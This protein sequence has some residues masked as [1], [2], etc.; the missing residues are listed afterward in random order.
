MSN[1]QQVPTLNANNLSAPLIC[2]SS[3]AKFNPIDPE[4]LFLLS[5]TLSSHLTRL[6]T[7]YKNLLFFKTIVFGSNTPATIADTPISTAHD[8]PS[9]SCHRQRARSPAVSTE[10]HTKA[11]VDTSPNR[12]C[13][14][15]HEAESRGNHKH[16]IVEEDDVELSQPL[17]A[18]KLTQQVEVG[19]AWSKKKYFPYKNGD[20]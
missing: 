12:A 16:S 2:P 7:C 3:Y 10:G 1:G 13:E 4:L 11:S 20:L 15:L 14:L 6:H 17:H 8:S 9:L 18:T 5:V 19:D